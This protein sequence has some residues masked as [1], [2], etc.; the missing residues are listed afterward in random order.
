VNRDLRGGRRL[1]RAVARTLGVFAVA[2]VPVAA[3]ST[4][5]ASC[6]QRDIAVLAPKQCELQ[7]VSLTVIASPLINPTVDGAPRPV[8]LRIYQLK[9]SI[10]MDNAP[11]D[12]IWKKDKET[13][14]EDIV[15][16]DELSVFPDSRTEVKFE[17]AK[18]A[19][20]VVAVALFRNPKGRSWYTVFELPPDPGKGACGLPVGAPSGSADCPD[21][22]CDNADAGPILNPRF[23]V[24]IDQNRVDVGDDHLDEYPDGGRTQVIHL[25]SGGAGSGSPATGGAPAGSK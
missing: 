17:R 3:A 11:F 20:N 8:Q 22:K 6:G 13:L 15:K 21:G 19:L 2:F 14:G 4:M 10:R 24:W 16:V 7:I 18:D 5:L 9:S 25:S 12:A 1:G 23:S